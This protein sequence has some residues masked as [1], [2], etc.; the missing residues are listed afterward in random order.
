M[1]GQVVVTPRW[2]PRR[3]R[4]LARPWREVEYLV[5]DLETTGLDLQRDDIAS[6]GAVLIRDGRIVVAENT[7]GL[8]CPTCEITAESTTVH[9]LRR[10]DVADAPPLSEAVAVL[11]TLL[12]DRVL[13]AHAAWIE[14]AFLGRAFAEH[15]ATMRS[16]IIDT[17]ALARADG[18]APRG[19]GREPDLEWLAGEIGLPAVNPHHALGDAITTAQV[20]L[21]LTSRLAR[22]GY[23]K[24]SD[25]VD[26]T[27][28]DRAVAKR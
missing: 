21:A 16:P 12:W 19:S 20:F 10:A 24:A 9:T 23:S 1:D 28:G 3:E 7:Y 5:V 11:D 14:K 22:L 2:W 6:Y 13:V 17:A 15:G 18:I 4:P 26:L 25:F 27:A 8:V